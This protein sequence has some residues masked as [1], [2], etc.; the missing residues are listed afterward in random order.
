MQ[1]L[2]MTVKYHVAIKTFSIAMAFGTSST[3][4]IGSGGFFPLSETKLFSNTDT[5]Q[6]G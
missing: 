6:M 4:S 5:E 2:W 3:Q 1:P